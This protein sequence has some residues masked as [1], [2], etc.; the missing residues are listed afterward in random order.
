M[1]REQSAG[2]VV[3]RE[4]PDGLQVA[5]IQPR[6]RTVWALPKGHLDA[7]ETPEI[8]AAREIREETGL[9]ADIDVPLGV[10]RYSYQFRG[11]RVAKEVRFF[12]FRYV[13]GQIDELDPS[14]RMEVNQA[15]WVALSE[16]TRTLAY[17]GEREMG[18]RA[19]DV[20]TQRFAAKAG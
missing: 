10:I 15:K 14:M 13:T 4:G 20:L 8:A 12:L 1:E 16:L 11:R 3:F 19:V 6:G 17:A 7:G 9:C 18:Q 5:V 2:G